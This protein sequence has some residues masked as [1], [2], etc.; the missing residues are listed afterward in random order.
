MEV[1]EDALMELINQ[2]SKAMHRLGYLESLIEFV[3]IDG[4]ELSEEA[5]NNLSETFYDEKIR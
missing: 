2:H 5:R 3:I 4:H 1:K